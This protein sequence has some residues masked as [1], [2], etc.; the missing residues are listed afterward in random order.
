MKRKVALLTC[1]CCLALVTN[2]VVIKY[3]RSFTVKTS[4]I[5]ASFENGMIVYVK[6][7]LTGEVHASS[8]N[9]NPL[10][11]SGMGTIAEDINA[12][13]NLHC[14]WGTQSC[15][16]S[17]A[18][19]HRADSNSQYQCVDILNGV[20]ATWTGLTNGNSSFANEK[21]II[22][23]WEDTSGTVNI[24]A[25]AESS[26]NGVYGIQVPISNLH[27]NH[28][29]YV[30][31]FGG[32]KYN[33]S[34][35]SCLKTLGCSPYWEAPVVAMEGTSGSIGLWIEEPKFRDSFFFLNYDGNNFSVSI[36]C[37]NLKPF[38]Q[39]NSIESSI[40][41]LNA[42]NGGWVA[43]MTPYKQWY[44]TTFANEIA[45][46]DA[47]NWAKDIRVVIDSAEYATEMLSRIASIFPTET[48]LFH[49]WNARAPAFD[50]ELPDWTPRAGY[51]D[52]VSLI[53][54]YGFKAMA[55]VNSY[56]INYNSPVFINDNIS[57]FGLTRK[58]KSLWEYTDVLPDF[59]TATNGLLMYLDPLSELWRQYHIDMM[60]QWKQ[61]TSTD[62][63]YEDTAGSVGDYGNG[64]IGGLAGAEGAAAQFKE[65]LERNPQVPMASEFCPESIAFAIHWPLRYQQVW[66]GQEVKKWW[67]VNQRP[68]TS[69]I[70]GNS[71]WI[72]VINAESSFLQHLVVSCSDA[73]G[74]FG[75]V[76]A[77]NWNL[78]ATK[79]V[80]AHLLK[81]AKFFAEKKLSPHFSTSLNSSDLACQYIDKFGQIYSYYCNSNVQK[82]VDSN[83]LEIYARIN[84][85]NE[86]TPSVLPSFWPAIANNK[87]IGLD[88]NERYVFDGDGSE[89][90]I[91]VSQL[92]D[93]TKVAKYYETEQYVVL[94]LEPIAGQNSSSGIIKCSTN[95]TFNAL[96]VNGVHYEG[97]AANNI[98]QSL[99]A[100][101]FESAIPLQIIFLKTDGSVSAI[102]LPLGDGNE[103]ARYILKG[104][105]LERG[106]E[107]N[108]LQGT[109]ILPDN[110]SNSLPAQF[111][112][113]GDGAEVLLDYLVK[114]P[115]VSN[116]ALR[117]Y[118]KN[119]HS[120][121]GNGSI[122]R[123]YING[124]EVHEYDFLPLDINGSSVHR[125]TLPMSAYSGKT[126]LIS[127]GNDA[128]DSNN[129][130]NCWVTRP[131]F[132]I[133]N[134]Q[135][136]DFVKWPAGENTIQKEDNSFSVPENEYS[137]Y[138]KFDESLLDSSLNANDAEPINNPSWV[139][140][141]INKAIYLQSINSQ[142]LKLNDNDLFNYSKGFS[143]STWLNVAGLPSN[144]A[145]IW[146]DID[147]YSQNGVLIFLNQ[148]GKICFRVADSNGYTELIS[149]NSIL[150]SEWFHLACTY[151]NSVMKIYI[152]GELVGLKKCN[153]IISDNSTDK[154]IGK[155]C[156]GP[157]LLDGKIDDMRI[158]CKSLTLS[159][160]SS[161][162]DLR[163]HF[164]FDSSY[165][166]TAIDNSSYENHAELIN[167]SNWQK[168]KINGAI[169]LDNLNSAYLKIPDSDSFNYEKGV[170]YSTYIK[171]NSLP[172]N[173]SGIWSDIDV[174]G[175]N[176]IIVYLKSDGK[177]HF[178]IA[179]STG[180]TWLDSSTSLQ[181]DKWYHIA[182]TYDNS[183]M[184]IYINGELNVESN[185][186][187][188]ISDNNYD[189]LIGKV[190]WGPYY[191]DG[192][193]DD[194]RIYSHALKSIDIQKI[195]GCV[196]NWNFDCYYNTILADSSE[197]ANKA[198]MI[199]NPQMGI[200]KF[201]EAISLLIN[202]NQY[203]EVADDNSFNYSSGF[204]F[205]TWIK[206]NAFH[207]DISGIWSDIDTYS[208]NG[209]I[210]YLKPDGKV[211]FRIADSSGFTWLDSSISLQ[212]DKWYHIACTYDNSV[213]K[214]YING[215]LD[216]EINCNRIISDNNS[217]KLIG[218]VCWGPYYLDGMLDDMCIYTNALNPIDIKNT[219]SIAGYW[220][221][222]A[223][224][225]NTA[226]DNSIHE[227]HATTI[228]A[229]TFSSG[230]ISGAID[231]DSS[232]SQYLT[233]SDNDSFNY[234]NGMGVSAWINVASLPLNSAGI[235]S[236]IDTY[237]KNGVIIYLKPDGIIHF[238][239]SDASSFTWLE[240]TIP[241]QT[242]QWFHLYCTYDNSVMKI[243]ING[244]LSNSKTCNLIVSDNN[245][246]KLIGK[247]SWG[248]YY[249]NGKIDD[250]RIYTHSLDISDVLSF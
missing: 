229:P 235:W 240:S 222:D 249:L 215:K 65:A 158:Y 56:C 138:W 151:D 207:S 69:Y 14:I 203:L 172:S 191:L 123:L 187:R 89:T 121:Y 210:V 34:I 80:S 218:K 88:P 107:H 178:R 11:P 208:K 161:V 50:T 87:I 5:E 182:C 192:M 189:K 85:L 153:R 57:S 201:G 108:L 198:V 243:Y 113:G 170:S 83:N 185:C 48:V 84:G 116:P 135:E 195:C 106:G 44:E 15:N 221:F 16:P 163:A 100:G 199:N 60:I 162:F 109:L 167:S 233:I 190:C 136:W 214:I 231:L 134:A 103:K 59:Q 81:R 17:N 75:Q 183:V 223:S 159:A 115:E 40:Y 118:I 51:A 169:S 41:K 171:L 110:T 28:N 147:N 99:A 144:S 18:S 63:N 156:W 1:L 97:N 93:Y 45:K 137:V 37:F 250:M 211:H 64:V 226:D 236:D 239:I 31:S 177:V 102:N 205:S 165:G 213:M 209:T 225:G 43:A 67:M 148:D 24:K 227:N 145:G 242:G 132:L 184:K 92:P 202:N 175:K 142:Y 188:I 126:I 68:V 62:A 71:P 23:V 73:L 91:K 58:K 72:P 152:N 176:G 21:I 7:L 124:R 8:T 20:R 127:I 241:V 36:E 155:I 200:G 12:A 157:Y 82:L 230:Q 10:I 6:N 30:P 61:Q 125:W 232:S 2:A 55:Y 86:Y 76:N 186:N 197:Y 196:G 47:V 70:Y 104:M 179:D 42:F 204:S 246:S 234:S 129:S 96:I 173:Y 3:P 247:V 38:E 216:V 39:H 212:L 193:L 131:I 194:M 119:N 90:L 128:K 78:D 174:Y 237:S 181:L 164:K 33:S 140:G 245:S 32:V 22:E 139:N 74:G 146:S 4:S 66:G 120:K 141:K 149:K 111:I 150:T 224:L 117:I 180:F 112:S 19:L 9:N 122:I 154:L 77:K 228:N 219:F 217:D 25:K 238:R 29:I 49:E 52:R 248:S 54:Q 79:G 220:K 143:L 244:E 46:R 101:T 133:D 114:V 166:F 160:V 27:S 94:G 130:D 168:G 206:L 26:Q 105:G 53:H 95:A 35:G 13:M 98:L